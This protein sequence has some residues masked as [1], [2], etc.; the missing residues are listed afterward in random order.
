MINGKVWPLFG[1][2]FEKPTVKKK[3]FMRQSQKYEPRIFNSIKQLF[4]GVIMTL[5][6][7]FLF[8]LP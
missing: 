2:Q 7:C 3:T 5:E 1:T 8:S 6:L 4:L